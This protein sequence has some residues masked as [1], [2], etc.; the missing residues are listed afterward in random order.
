M[1]RRTVR[2]QGHLT[3]FPTDTRFPDGG[4]NIPLRNLVF[5]TIKL[6]VLDKTDRVI[7]TDRT[8][9]K[10]LRIIRK[11]WGDHCQRWHVRVPVFRRM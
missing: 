9:Q 3:S 5:K 11:G 10:T 7:A 8:L 4:Q 1:G 2:N 6:F